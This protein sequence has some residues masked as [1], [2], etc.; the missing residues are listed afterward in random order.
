MIG[1]VLIFLVYAGVFGAIFWAVVSSD[2]I[3]P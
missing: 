3:T 1:E 2:D